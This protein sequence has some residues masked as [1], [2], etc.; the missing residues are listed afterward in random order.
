MRL[1]R[2]LLQRLQE[3]NL[4]AQ[5]KVFANPLAKSVEDVMED[6]TL[7][8]NSVINFMAEDLATGECEEFRLTYV[9]GSHTRV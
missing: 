2:Y 8:T 5:L 1:A 4:E 6:G 3:E 7:L 9:S